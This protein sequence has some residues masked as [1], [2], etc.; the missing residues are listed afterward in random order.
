MA[1]KERHT[2][3]VHT[4]QTQLPLIRVLCSAIY[5]VQRYDALRAV[6]GVQNSTVGKADA[7]IG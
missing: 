2:K 4:E 1:S 7:V 5:M 6:F 3:I